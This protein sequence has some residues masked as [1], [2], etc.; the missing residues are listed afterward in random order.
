MID[1]NPKDCA[2]KMEAY[3]F[4]WRRSVNTVNDLLG[5][6]LV[7]EEMKATIFVD[8]TKDGLGGMADAARV[9]Q[10]HYPEIGKLMSSE[11]SAQRIHIA[12]VGA[13]KSI[14]FSSDGEDGAGDS[15][16]SHGAMLAFPPR[17]VI[18]WPC[19]MPPSEE[20][21]LKAL[22]LSVNENAKGECG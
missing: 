8:P 18:S 4:L 22:S 7:V 2:P 19:H 14:H 11:G 17:E 21:L 3:N 1:P 16:L 9:A 6:C 13:E 15:M 20:E 5:F 12:C 10:T